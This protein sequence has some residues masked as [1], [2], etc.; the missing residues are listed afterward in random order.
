MTRIPTRSAVAAA[1]AGALLAAGAALAQTAPAPVQ[2]GAY[3][4]E[5]THAQVLFAVSHMGFSTWYGDFS[6]ATGTLTLDPGN[7]A[8]DALDVSIPV[9]SVRTTNATLDGELKGAA[10][11]DAGAFPAILFHSTKV[12]QTGPDAATVTGDLTL[13]GVTRPVT[14]QATFKGAGVNPLS[15]GYTV[16]FDVRG[17]LKRSDFGVKTYVPL[18]GDDVDLIISAP[19]EKK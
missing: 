3:R 19:F 9:A 6:G 4:L 16:G 13:H 2:A 17:R 7:A 12:V 8:A 11:L 18:I 14:L 10:W 15:K 1:L 5:T